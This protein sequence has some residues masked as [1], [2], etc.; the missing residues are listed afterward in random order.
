M[1]ALPE[2]VSL[3]TARMVVVRPELRGGAEVL[4]GRAKLPATLA[5]PPVDRTR[6]TEAG[7]VVLRALVGRLAAIEPREVVIEA[8]CPDCGAPHGRPVVMGPDAA[9][10]IRVSLAYAGTAIVAAVSVESAIGVDAELRSTGTTPDAARR[11]AA[12]REAVRSISGTDSDSVDPL[13]RWTRIEAVL[14]ADGRGLRVDP[15]AVAFI[16][17]TDRLR[18]TV[19]GGA[20]SYEVHDLQLGDDLFASVAVELSAAELTAAEKR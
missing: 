9:K 8:R 12:R 16:A 1:D 17:D 6:R 19:A 20:Q 11:D 3:D 10:T 2:V 13:I 4:I 7:R 15:S 14:K 5:T 18:A